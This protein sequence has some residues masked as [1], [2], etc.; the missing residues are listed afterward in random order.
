MYKD[1][2]VRAVAANQQIRAFAITSKNLVEE[3]RSRHDTSPLATAALGR[4]LSGTLMMSDML[5][6]D[7]DLITVKF[8]GNGPLG[9]VTATADHHGNVKGF[10][11]NP[12]V[13]LPLKANGHL[14]VGQGIG[15]GTLTVI[16]DLDLKNTYSGQVAIHSG[17]IADDLT[18]YF[19]DSE[20]VPSS[21]GLGV[22]VD[23]D[24]TVRR[25][26]GFLVQLMPFAD[27]AIIDKL[28]EN[29]R[30]LE[31]VTVMLE[32]GMTPEDMLKVV[33]D[34][35]DVEFNETTDVQFHCNCD[36]DRVER[37]L[38]LIGTKDLDEIIEAGKE[39]ELACQ[40]CGKKYQFSI[41]DVKAIREEIRK[42]QEEK[43]Q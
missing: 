3:A 17:E 19:V 31:D 25:A 32:K 38:M 2:M 9:A 39:I 11:Q 7:K 29:L 27:D 28:E 22:L 34:G 18:Y 5:K 30:H 13:E 10:I 20:Q 4:V 14:D 37:A 40:F 42:Q 26:G 6:N 33:L 12:H 1:Y 24:C 35:F 8:E 43:N 16:R 36:R 15:G 23:T 41:E 21:V